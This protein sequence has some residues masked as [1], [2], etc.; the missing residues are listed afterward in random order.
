[1]VKKFKNYATN[2]GIIVKNALI[3]VYHS[4]SMVEYYHRPLRQV[5]SIITIK[6]LAIKP[7]SAFQIF[8]KAINNSIGPNGRVCTLL[9]FGAYP[10]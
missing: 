6:I 3:E 9:V 5:Y 1:M 4:I 2:M 8:F 10:S 7:D